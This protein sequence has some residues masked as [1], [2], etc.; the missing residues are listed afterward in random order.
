MK[1]TAKGL[2]AAVLLT[3]TAA[4]I[5]FGQVGVSG[6]NGISVP[7]ETDVLLSVPVSRPIKEALTVNGAPAGTTLPVTAGALA[8][9]SYDGTY[10]VRFTSGAAEGLWSTVVSNTDDDVTIADAAVAAL[11]ADQDTFRIHEHHTVGSLFPQLH[12]DWSYTAGTQILLFDNTATGQFKVADDILEYR[13][14]PVARWTSGGAAT[15]IPP[16]T[17][18]ILRNNSS[19]KTLH[20]GNAGLVPDYTVSYLLPAGVDKDIL[21]GAGYPVATTVDGTGF[22]GVAGRQILM[23]DN[24]ATGRFKVADDILEYRT[25]PVARWTSGGGSTP[26]PASEAFIFRQKSDDPGG[27]IQT[28]RPY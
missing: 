13:L 3:L 25:V 6:F 5:G 15:I 21:I 22:G 18:F 26:I 24:Q 8:G 1:A 14:V 10:Y 12:Y 20:Y 11:V 4:S 27:V 17:M 16:E 2:A 28:T 7:P 23:F 9:S 19:T